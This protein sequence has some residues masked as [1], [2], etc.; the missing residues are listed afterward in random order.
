MSGQFVHFLGY[1][2][3]NER[4]YVGPILDTSGDFKDYLSVYI[5]IVAICSTAFFIFA[6]PRVYDYFY[7]LNYRNYKEML[8]LRKSLVDNNRT[9]DCRIDKMIDHYENEFMATRNEKL[10]NLHRDSLYKSAWNMLGF[11]FLVVITILG[12]SMGIYRLFLGWLAL[13]SLPIGNLELIFLFF[14]NSWLR[15]IS[16]GVLIWTTIWKVMIP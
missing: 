9:V 4:I 7:N 10:L 13:L 3:E 15:E 14:F 8:D 11:I 2:I 1:A 5:S 16:N 6:L 12:I